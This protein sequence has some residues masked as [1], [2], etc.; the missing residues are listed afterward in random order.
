MATA[1]KG[2]WPM[3]KAYIPKDI[4]GNPI[5]EDAL[6]DEIRSRHEGRPPPQSET[7]RR[8]SELDLNAP[9]P[10]LLSEKEWYESRRKSFEDITKKHFDEGRKREGRFNQEVD[11]GIRNAIVGS[12]QFKNHPDALEVAEN[13][14]M[15]VIPH[16]ASALATATDPIYEHE[17]KRRKK[18]LK[19]KKYKL[20]KDV[21]DK[22]RLSP[23]TSEA[24]GMAVLSLVPLIHNG[25][26]EIDRQ[27]FNLGPVTVRGAG[28]LHFAYENPEDARAQYDIDARTQDIAGLGVDAEARI[29]GT[30][31]DFGY[32]AEATARDV[33]GSGVDVAGGFGGDTTEIRRANLEA[34]YRDPTFSASVEASG[35]PARPEYGRVTGDVTTQDI[36]GL[37]EILRASA[38]SRIGNPELVNFDVGARVPVGEGDISVDAGGDVRRGL[39]QLSGRYDVPVGERGNFY[40]GVST[41][42][43]EPYRK[44]AGQLGYRVNWN[45]GGIVD[46]P[47]QSPKVDVTVSEVLAQSNTKTP[48]FMAP[49]LLPNPQPFQQGGIASL[50]E[51]PVLAGQEHMLAYITPEEASTLRAQGGGVTPTG[52]QYRGP[53]GIASFPFGAEGVGHGVST[54]AF[55]GHA[56]MGNLSV[57]PYSMMTPPKTKQ[58]DMLAK[59]TQEVAETVANKRAEDS[60]KALEKHEVNKKLQAVTRIPEGTLAHSE[61]KD[62]YSAAMGKAKADGYSSG[63]IGKANQVAN[64][65]KKDFMGNQTLALIDPSGKRHTAIDIAHMSDTA[66]SALSANPATQVEGDPKSPLGKAVLGF[67]TTALSMLAPALTPATTAMSVAYGLANPKQPSLGPLGLA[68]QALGTTLGEVAGDVSQEMGLGRDPLGL[69]DFSFTGYIGDL[70]S[71]ADAVE[72]APPAADAGAVQGQETVYGG[73]PSNLG[74]GIS[75]PPP[76]EIPSVDIGLPVPPTTATETLLDATS[77]FYD[78]QRLADA[79]GVTLAQAEDYLASR[80]PQQLT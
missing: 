60:V 71:P 34:S 65:N 33:A 40:A 39:T 24:V 52:G 47:R 30:N 45:N 43:R 15:D 68:E 25:E 46:L 4:F 74:P 20:L 57:D 80:Y 9:V 54:A 7:Q 56:S 67:G 44:L 2:R 73:R 76:A 41:D 1:A 32:D 5:P 10:E 66:F 31:L 36:F 27:Q 50:P 59:N 3:A 26:L 16:A 55:G 69:S 72:A 64:M 78:A 35:N 70:F 49:V 79:T 58:L 53:G 42:P 18:D 38:N 62:A 61:A 29:R 13:I 22:F 14:A 37:G 6:L 23:E 77:S 19:L 75:L 21:Q 63:A 8:V 48:D 28:E 51:N 12:K 11:A 17:Y